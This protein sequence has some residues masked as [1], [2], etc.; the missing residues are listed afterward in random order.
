MIETDYLLDTNILIYHTQG[1][2]QATA[3]I[4]DLLF[5]RS[6]NI[7]ILTKIEFLGWDKH[8]EEGFSKCKKL[9][10]SATVYPVDET[11]A[12]KTIELR[13]H[14]TIKLAD[15]IIAATA[16]SHKLTLV[17][18]NIDDFKQIDGL[19]SSNPIA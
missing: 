16:L 13:R 19:I 2:P 12:A 4:T 15:A 5:R 17:T 14:R 11:I 1:S 3:L 18:R 7:S 8:T 9:I 10:E 6:L